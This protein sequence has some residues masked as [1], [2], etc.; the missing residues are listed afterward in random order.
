MR[1]FDAERQRPGLPSDV[2]ALVETISADRTVLTLVNLSPLAHRHVI[3]QAGGF[4]EHRFD[5]VRYD[6]RTSEYPGSHKMYASPPLAT[7]TAEAAVNDKYLAVML[8]P[9]TQITLDLATARHV[10]S[11]SY[12]TPFWTPS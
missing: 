3:I 12:Q 7:R 11:P 4:G 9:A 2:A 8:P 5:A 1:Y 10:N 6:M